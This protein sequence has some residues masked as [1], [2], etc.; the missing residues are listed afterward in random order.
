MHYAVATTIRHGEIAPRHIE[1]AALNDPEIAAILPTITVEATD[2]HS[3][4]FPAERFSDV[5][6]TLNNGHTLTSGD[7]RASGGPGTWRTDAEV[8]AKFH[9]FCDGVL[10]PVRAKAIWTMRNRMLEPDSHLTD[11]ATLLPEPPDA[12]ANQPPKN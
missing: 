1:G 7:I 3:A 2:H 10:K 5:D 8:E 6:M 9:S 12:R 11:L 4:L